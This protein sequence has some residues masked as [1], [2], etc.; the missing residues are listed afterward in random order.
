[1]H[2]EQRQRPG[3]PWSASVRPFFSCDEVELEG[4][5]PVP[6]GTGVP[7]RPGA[8]AVG[9]AEGGIGAADGPAAA[10]APVV[11]PVGTNDKEGTIKGAGYG[12]HLLSPDSDNGPC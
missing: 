2:R 10:G 4:N 6:C 3:V 5:T 9:G 12:E 7:W 1:M 8:D 11:E